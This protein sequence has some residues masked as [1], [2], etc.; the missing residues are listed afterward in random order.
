MVEWHPYLNMQM[1]AK[2]QTQRGARMQAQVVTMMRL[3]RFSLPESERR[4]Y[5]EK[6]RGKGTVSIV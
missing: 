4:V 2:N 3:Q 6:G 1:V 5:V